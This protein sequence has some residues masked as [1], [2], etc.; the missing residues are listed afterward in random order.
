MAEKTIGALIKEARTGANLTQEQLAKKVKIITAADISAAERGEKTLTQ[1]ALKEIAK[2][3]GVTQA[4]LLNAAK[5]TSDKKTSEKKTTAKKTTSTAA[6]KTSI[7]VTA[8][9]KKLVELYRKADADVQKNALNVLKG[10][11]DDDDSV[12]QSIMDSLSGLLKDK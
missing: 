11:D 1:S 7:S 6:K 8:A 3:T 10:K 9:E 12:L 2:A 5:G 4:S